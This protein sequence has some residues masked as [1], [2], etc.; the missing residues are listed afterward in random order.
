MARAFCRFQNGTTPVSFRLC[1]ARRRECRQRDIRAGAPIMSHDRV[2]R[3]STRL[4]SSH[5]YIS[6]AVFCL[7]KKS[8]TRGILAGPPAEPGACAAELLRHLSDAAACTV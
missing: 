7:K 8:A 2:D 6:Y 4:N 3:K 5:G 1:S